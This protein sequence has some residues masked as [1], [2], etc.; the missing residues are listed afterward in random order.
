MNAIDYVHALDIHKN[1]KVMLNN[2]FV[3]THD[4]PLNL[5][6]KLKLY[7]RNN[8]INYTTSVSWDI[9]ENEIEIFS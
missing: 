5:L 3:G 9:I 4:D 7:K 8:I 1:T 6:K 2:N